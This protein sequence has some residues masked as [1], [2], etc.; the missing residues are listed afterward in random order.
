[1]EKE[2]A[3][4]EIFVIKGSVGKLKLPDSDIT[5]IET[6]ESVEYYCGTFHLG[7]K[8]E[9]R[10]RSKLPEPKDE[11]EIWLGSKESEL[12]KVMAGYVDRVVFEKK[13]G[14]SETMEVFGR[15]YASLLV[16]SRIAGKIEYSDGL[17][18]VI[19][20]IIKKTPFRPDDIQDISG[21][22]IVFFRNT[23]LID[24]IRQVAEEV[25]WEFGIDHDKVF[26]FHPYVKRES[27]GKLDLKDAKSYRL[28]KGSE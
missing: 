23:P 18:Q 6:R 15:S 16:D 9:S 4:K 22:G 28:V 8:S 11:V 1:M 27:V 25:N 24:I 7:L 19:R 13:E 17:S 20:E 10:D 5:K 12:K 14:S 26:H 3:V 2:N 21:K